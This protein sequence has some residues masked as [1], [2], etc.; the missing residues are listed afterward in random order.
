MTE[1]WFAPVSQDIELPGG[2]PA[3]VRSVGR[4]FP[5]SWAA[6]DSL[7]TPGPRGETAAVSTRVD[8]GRRGPTRA[9]AA[10]EPSPDLAVPWPT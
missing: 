9:D 8:A 7:T 4:G 6:A 10:D 2:S 1:S 3:P 5:T